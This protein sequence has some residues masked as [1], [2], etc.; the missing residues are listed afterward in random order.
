MVGTSI[1]ELA[2]L[3]ARVGRRVL[4]LRPSRSGDHPDRSSVACATTVK[5]GGSEDFRIHQIAIRRQL[6]W[7]E[8][9]W[10]AGDLPSAVTALT[11]AAAIN[12]ELSLDD[13]SAG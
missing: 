7:A 1:R 13:R 8:E 11:D 9:F 12:A 6:E 3:G 4:A 5:Y 2:L 10:R